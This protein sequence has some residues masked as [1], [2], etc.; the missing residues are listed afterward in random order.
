MNSD[1]AVMTIM[2]NYPPEKYTMLREALDFAI[3]SMGQIATL[4]AALVEQKSQAVDWHFGE[5]RTREEIAKEQ[6]AQE[7]PAIFGDG[8]E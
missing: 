1:E 7:Y 5:K 3:M 6:L 8:E 2:S 4:K